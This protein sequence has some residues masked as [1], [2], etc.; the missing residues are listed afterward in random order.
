MKGAERQERQVGVKKLTLIEVR[1]NANHSKKKMLDGDT[2]IRKIGRNGL[3]IKPINKDLL[4][5]IKK[6]VGM[7][8]SNK[9]SRRG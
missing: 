5:K 8:N 1:P 4:N 6:D 2:I 9:R 7:Y 3:V